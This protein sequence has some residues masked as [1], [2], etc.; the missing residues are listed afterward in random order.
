[1]LTLPVTLL[2]FEHSMK[3]PDTFCTFQSSSTCGL[4]QGNVL[5]RGLGYHPNGLKDIVIFSETRQIGLCPP[6]VFFKY[7]MM[8]PPPGVMDT[9]F[10]VGWRGTADKHESTGRARY[11]IAMK[12]EAGWLVIPHLPVPYAF[13]EPGVDRYLIYWLAWEVGSKYIGNWFHNAPPIYY[14][15]ICLSPIYQAFYLSVCLYIYVPICP[16]T[17]P[18]KDPRIC[19]LVYFSA[20]PLSEAN[21]QSIMKEAVTVK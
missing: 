19:L 18:F 17:H 4:C 13:L 9:F 11:A 12:Q 1:M 14:W 7:S 21:S 20:C 3:M 15:L 10:R 5:K 6:C 2:Y 16:S 8:P